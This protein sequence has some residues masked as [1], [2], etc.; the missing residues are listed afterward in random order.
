MTVPHAIDSVAVIGAGLIGVGWAT[1]FINAGLPV[2][3]FDQN[4]DLLA[5]VE[6]QIADNLAEMRSSELAGPTS[7]SNAKITICTSIDEA[8]AGV[9]YVQESVL[10]V[11]DIKRDVSV[12]IDAVLASHAIVGSSSSGIPASKYTEGLVNRSRFFVVHPVNPPHLIPVVE[13]VP[14][15]WSEAA[16]IPVIRSFMEHIGQQPVVLNREIDGFILNRLQGALL[17]EAW[18]LFADGYASAADIDRTVSAGLGLRWSFMGPFETI[19]LNAPGGIADYAARLSGLYY[20]I[21]QSRMN[22]RPWPKTAVERAAAELGT[23]FSKISHAD[24]IGERDRRLL[25][26]NRHKRE[27]KD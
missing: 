14:A 19:D 8:V 15:D 3:I 25:A 26:L 18:A 21:A 7:R 4:A 16:L 17:N 2:S 23:T 13:I 22:P 6:Q 1:I 27:T 20:E 9:D 24:R 5:T 11:L 10:E 12:A